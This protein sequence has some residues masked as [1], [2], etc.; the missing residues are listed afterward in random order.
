[1]EYSLETLPAIIIAL[2]LEV[3]I[4]PVNRF[5]ERLQG[6]NVRRTFLVHNMTTTIEVIVERDYS[7]GTEIQFSTEFP[8]KL[9]GTANSQHYESYLTIQ[10]LSPMSNSITLSQRSTN[11]LAALSTL[12]R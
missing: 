8:A 4:P 10:D 5:C 3:T 11:R 12:V 6:R 9:E 7:H 1:L 2:I